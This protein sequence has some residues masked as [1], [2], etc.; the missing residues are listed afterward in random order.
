MLRLVTGGS[1]SGKSAFAEKLAIEEKKKHPAG[2]L[3]YVA[4]MVPYDEECQERIRRHRR[5]RKD[6]DFVTRECHTD[7]SSLTAEKEDV[8]LIECL[9]NLLANEMYEKTGRLQ[10]KSSA[11]SCV[12]EVIA[13]PVRR[14]AGQCAAVIVVTNEVFSEGIAFPQE[15]ALYLQLLGKSNCLLARAADS[16]T[17]V[18][19]GIPVERKK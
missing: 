8:F 15:T 6:K 3:Y 5:I 9:S 12:E 10:E 16:V 7:L 14:L 2:T 19:C 1:C 4:T 18:I 11:P 17:E 13:A